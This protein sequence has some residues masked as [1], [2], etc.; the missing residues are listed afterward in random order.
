[1][2]DSQCT[3]RRVPAAQAVTRHCGGAIDASPRSVLVHEEAMPTPTPAASARASTNV[4]RGRRRVELSDWHSVALITFDAQHDP[5]NRQIAGLQA[6]VRLRYD[7]ARRPI[8][9]CWCARVQRRIPSTSEH[10]IDPSGRPRWLQQLAMAVAARE[11]YRSICTS[12]GTD[13]TAWS[14]STVP[15]PHPANAQQ[16]NGTQKPRPLV[17]DTW[18]RY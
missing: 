15:Q 13:D 2:R 14:R 10:G 9:T 12:V 1:M 17:T 6:C 5:R 16:T 18:G 4:L 8:G 3:R 11:D 7:A